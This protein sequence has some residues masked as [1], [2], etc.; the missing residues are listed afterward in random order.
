MYVAKTD[1]CFL[2][3]MQ[4][5]VHCDWRIALVDSL[6]V[7]VGRTTRNGHIYALCACPFG[8]IMSV[9]GQP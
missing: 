4:K 2:S 3:R 9:L 5:R 7:Y 8:D 6:F 1:E